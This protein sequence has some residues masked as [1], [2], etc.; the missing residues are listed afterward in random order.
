MKLPV[1]FEQFKSDP[2]KA[3]T[4]LLIIVVTVLYIRSESQSKTANARCEKRLERCE[5]ELKKMSA[6]LKS[7]DSLCSA[8]VTEITIYKQLGKI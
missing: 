2:S 4:Y 5:M 6:M 1:S 8:L 7:Q 3:I